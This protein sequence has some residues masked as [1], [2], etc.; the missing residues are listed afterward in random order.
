MK[1]M[2]DKPI[3]PLNWLLVMLVLIVM[4][5]ELIQKMFSTSVMYWHKYEGGNC[6]IKHFLPYIAGYS[7][8]REAT[9]LYINI[10]YL[11]YSCFKTVRFIKPKTSSPVSGEFYVVG[12]DFQGI[13]EDD[14]TL[15][16]NHLD[17]MKAN[18]CF[19][20]KGNLPD[21][22]VKQVLQF[23][24]TLNEF[25]IEQKELRMDLLNCA[26]ELKEHNKKQKYSKVKI[27]ESDYVKQMNCRN[28]TNNNWIK[29]FLGDKVEVWVRENNFK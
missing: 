7:E 22:F 5:I 2:E 25:N 6:I 19:I 27:S 23:F 28:Y 13:D 29:Q 17:N 9:A 15:L 11:Y 20:K 12:M 8:S 24:I 21:R 14:L 4:L 1:N 3:G 16:Y 18:E 10:M 26:I